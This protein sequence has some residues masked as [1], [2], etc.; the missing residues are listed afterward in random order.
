M[1]DAK[2]VRAAFSR[3][4][5]AGK[6]ATSTSTHSLSTSPYAEG[7][8]EVDLARDQE[9]HVGGHLL[10]VEQHVPGLGDAGRERADKVRHEDRR[11]VLRAG[12]K[13]RA[14]GGKKDRR[15]RKRVAMNGVKRQDGRSKGMEQRGSS[16][17]RCL[18]GGIFLFGFSQLFVVRNTKRHFPARTMY[19]EFPRPNLWLDR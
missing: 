16:K 14:Q 4:V 2:K 11:V 19:V 10:L 1:E 7:G 5:D 6:P 9:V 13:T 8:E 17:Q 18:M 15:R 12:G 3:S